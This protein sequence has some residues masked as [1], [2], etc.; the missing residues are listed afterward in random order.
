MN[1]IYWSI[2]QF[3]PLYERPVVPF[4]SFN[5]VSPCDEQSDTG[6][7][8]VCRIIAFRGV[9]YYLSLC[10]LFP[11]FREPHANTNPKPDPEARILDVG[12]RFQV[13]Y[14]SPTA[15]GQRPALSIL[16]KRLECT[17]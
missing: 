15:D 7:P 12:P 6:T 2:L 1:P 4:K 8:K 14:T 13:F 3:W 11:T 5:V 17:D 9:T 10:T 16:R